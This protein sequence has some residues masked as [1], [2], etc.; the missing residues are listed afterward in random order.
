MG[1]IHKY[2]KEIVTA[3]LLVVLLESA[4]Y[5]YF[6]L[7]REE[8]IETFKR[9]T[10]K[11]NALLLDTARH[12]LDG[13]SDVIYDIKINQPRVLALMQEAQD[14][15]KRDRV[16]NE[17]YAL[18]KP[19]YEFL[20]RNGIRQFHFHLPG[21]ISFLRFH[22]PQKFGDSLK[23]VRYS[24]D[25]VNKTKKVVRGFEEGRIFNGFRNVY[26]LFYH[27]K[28]VATVEISYSIR[29]IATTLTQKEEAFYGLLIE[30]SLV[31]KKV[32]K[33]NRKHYLPSYFSNRYLWDNKA[34]Q[35]L[36]FHQNKKEFLEW[37]RGFEKL[38][39]KSVAPLLEKKSSFLMPIR[40]QDKN[41]I[42][43]FQVLKNIA[44]KPV[45]Y[46][47]TFEESD[48][49]AQNAHHSMM[50][51][52][53]GFIIDFI[54]GVLFFLFLKS[55][56]DIKAALSFRS[57]YDPLTALLNRRGFETTYEAL[58]HTHKRTKRPYSLLFLDI[59]HFKKINDSFGHDVGDAV[60]QKLAE[61]LKKNLRESDVIARWGG[62]E[63]VVL[64]NDTDIEAAYKVAK[65][66]RRAIE[67]YHDEQ[68]PH[69]TISI[70]VSGGTYTKALE[71]LI[72]EA[73]S[74][75]YRAKKSGRNK[76][77]IYN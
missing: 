59:D 28:F 4:T 27:D 58:W 12:G 72:K 14:P 30:K 34:L 50:T 68:L 22:K 57:N 31:E 10:L 24:I 49:F 5:L 63:F 75:L 19:T 40:F 70:G 26:P 9:Y 33:E 67:E 7:M 38:L 74:A 21:S 42:V 20:K 23:G 45:G 39:A 69:F 46:I 16:R 17:L 32:W 71:H 37:L 13:K 3:F 61:I 47:V 8:K 54:V 48:F 51:M 60:L 6:D 56:R 36:Y 62:E 44:N 64:L 55:E 2:K 41:F 25:L 53:I 11:E 52:A 29:A 35:T 77:V 76:V 65:K 18:L 15:T 43:I 66:L 1:F 73:D